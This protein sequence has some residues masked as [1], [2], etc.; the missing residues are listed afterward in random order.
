SRPIS[1][2][3]D[4]FSYLQHEGPTLG[5]RQQSRN[6]TKKNYFQTTIRN[7]FAVRSGGELFFGGVYGLQAKLPL[8]P[9]TDYSH[10]S[11]GG[12]RIDPSATLSKLESVRNPL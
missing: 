7:D 3:I 6:G 8:P 1:L 5:S 4:H 12:S 11:C 2:Q 9:N 10:V